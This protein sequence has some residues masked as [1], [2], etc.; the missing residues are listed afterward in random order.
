MYIPQHGKPLEVVEYIV[1]IDN[2]EAFEYLQYWKKPIIT[3]SLQ[4]YEVPAPR[5]CPIICPPTLGWGHCITNWGLV[6][7]VF[8]HLNISPL[9]SCLLF[10]LLLLP[11]TSQTLILGHSPGQEGLLFHKW[12]LGLSIICQGGMYRLYTSIT[13]PKLTE[14]LRLM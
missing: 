1:G 10:L 2:E 9:H 6:G 4:C 13:A 5:L 7:G 12:A 3:L 8:V 14:R 11:R